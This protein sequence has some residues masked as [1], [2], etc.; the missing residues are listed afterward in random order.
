MKLSVNGCF[1]GNS[2]VSAT[3]GVLND[4]W[5]MVLAPFGSFLGQHPILFLLS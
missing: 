2:S 3:S 4:H 1:R 5:E